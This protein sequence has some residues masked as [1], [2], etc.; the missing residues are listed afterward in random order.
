[1]ALSVGRARARIALAV[2]VLVIELIATIGFAVHR[3][4]LVS[5]LCLVASVVG[6]GSLYLRVQVLRYVRDRSLR[7]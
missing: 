3:Q 7:L 4:W 2:I 6:A 1:M 5:A